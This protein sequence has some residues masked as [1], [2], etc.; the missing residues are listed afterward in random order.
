MAAE[1]I[2]DTYSYV[3]SAGKT[4]QAMGVVLFGGGGGGAPAADVNVTNLSELK[5]LPVAV[6]RSGSITAGGTSQTLAALNANR[7]HLFIQNISDGDL[8]MS[9]YGPAAVDGSGS[10]RIA[11]GLAARVLTRNAITIVGSATGQK[12]TATETN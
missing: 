1:K 9:E 11:P 4:Q 8:W 7:T 3:D 5:I 6:N 12:F 2:N 10:Y